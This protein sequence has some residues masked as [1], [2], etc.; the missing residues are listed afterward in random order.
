ML[1]QVLLLVRSA[2]LVG[3]RPR[4]RAHALTV[5]TESMLNTLEALNASNVLLAP[6]QERLDQQLVMSA[7]VVSTAPAMVR[8][9][10]ALVQL[11][12]SPMIKLHHALLVMLATSQIQQGWQA[13]MLVLVVATVP[14]GLRNVQTVLQAPTMQTRPKA[15]AMNVNLVRLLWL[16]P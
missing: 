8:T 7:A 16:A 10:A 2:S 13:V 4:R 11:E 9:T 6:M 5:R 1:L 3:T 15:F 12:R 14:L